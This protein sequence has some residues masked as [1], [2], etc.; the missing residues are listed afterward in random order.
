MGLKA[1]N[2]LRNLLKKGNSF[3]SYLVAWVNVAGSRGIDFTNVDTHILAE[4]A[5]HSLLNNLI[6]SSN[7]VGQIY[8]YVGFYTSLQEKKKSLQASFLLMNL[9]SVYTAMDKRATSCTPFL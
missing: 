5:R 1:L 8:E 4:V 9:F 7:S 6:F 2:S 3:F